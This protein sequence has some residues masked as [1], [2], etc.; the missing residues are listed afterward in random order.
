MGLTMSQRKGL[1]KAI[2][3]RYARADKAG[4]G[5]ILDE[6]CAIAGWHR[7]HARKAALRPSWSSPGHRVRQVRIESRCGADLLLG[8]VGYA[9]GQAAGADAGRDGGGAAA[10][11]R[12]GIEAAPPGKRAVDPP[13]VARSPSEPGAH[14]A[15]SL[16]TA[17]TARKASKTPRT[18]SG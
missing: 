6:L 1:T 17:A 10:V 15:P 16:P 7:N 2:A 5:R 13:T 12:A 4:K 3:T 14:R 8:Y 11:R 18:T 9:R